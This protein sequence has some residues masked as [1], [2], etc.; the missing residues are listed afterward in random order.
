MENLKQI[1]IESAIDFIGEI[2]AEIHYGKPHFKAFANGV[3][4]FTID[5]RRTLQELAQ[6]DVS[7]N[8]TWLD[9]W[10]LTFMFEDEFFEN[11]TYLELTDFK[12]N[13]NYIKK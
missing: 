2:S 12:K 7:F 5:C 11:I 6:I 3:F 8:T 13:I 9:G 10:D 4:T 1:E